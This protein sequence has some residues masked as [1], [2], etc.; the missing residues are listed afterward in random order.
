MITK[1]TTYLGK[2]VVISTGSTYRKLGIPGEEELIGSGIH[3]CATCDGAFYRD[4]DIIVIGGGNSALEEGIF[5]AG[6]CKSVKI[7]SRSPE[8]SASETY[9]EKLNTIKNISTYMNK[10]S[11]EF[12]AD[13]KGTFSSLKTIDNETEE[14]VNLTAD[15]VFIFIGLIPNTKPFK[16]SIDLDERGFIKTNGL[17]ETSEK[18]I[19]AAG[20]CRE[21]AIAQVAAAT[22]EGVLA[23]Y[24]IRNYLK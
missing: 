12:I 20:D 6:F 1:S 9:I 7:V 10:T 22:G 19:F 24:G 2:T 5:L 14:V 3:F 17:A 13:E 16:D 4:K 23:S 15:G 11:V 18:G 8:F 21:G